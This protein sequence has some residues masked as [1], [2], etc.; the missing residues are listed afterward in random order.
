MILVCIGVYYY[1]FCS[2]IDLSPFSVGIFYDDSAPINV[3]LCDYMQTYR[4]TISNY[5]SYLTILN[6]Y[7]LDSGHD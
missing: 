2:R 6:I 1:L 5:T 3:R 7:L 4:H